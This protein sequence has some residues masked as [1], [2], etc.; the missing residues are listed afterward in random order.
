MKKI[1]VTGC[2]GFIGHALCKKL[3]EEFKVYGLDIFEKN[4]E[5]KIKK[6][7]NLELLKLKNFR[8]KKIDIANFTFLN[9]YIIKIKPHAIINLAATPGVRNSFKNPD[10]YFKNNIL[11]FYNIYK[12]TI[13]NK[14]KLLIFGSSS[15]VYGNMN[16]NKNN[17]T[18]NPI[19]FYAA[20]KKCNEIIAHSFNENTKT[21]VVGL[22]FFTVY[23]PWGRPDMAVYK[24]TNKIFNNKKI[25][26][27]NSGKHT[28][29]FSYIDDVVIS[30]IKILK[31]ENKLKKYQILDIGK[32]QS[33]KLISL[34]R[35]I[36]NFSQK[37]FKIIKKKK[38][39]G[40]VNSTFSNNKNLFKLINFKPNTP[41]KVGIQH[42]VNW[43]KDYKKIKK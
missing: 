43:Y 9:N 39:I 42:F 19:S 13:S 24:F 41:L 11:G 34:I 35:Y 5:I 6:K 30:I 12:S 10:I 8:F 32:S 29:D 17:F 25:E 18:D 28:R 15:S 3:C 4:Y 26:L 14:I 27:F 20:T 33:D 1:L 36:E 2:A 38:Q 37:R 31:K 23:G 16:K 7:R 21:K 22:R 40:D